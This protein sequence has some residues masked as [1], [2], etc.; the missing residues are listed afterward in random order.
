MDEIANWNDDIESKFEE[1][2]FQ[3]LHVLVIGWRKTNA[4]LRL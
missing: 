1:A 2:D 4:K 3:K